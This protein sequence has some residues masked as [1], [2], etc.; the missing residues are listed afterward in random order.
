MNAAKNLFHNT[1]IIISKPFLFQ[2]CTS[3]SPQSSDLHMGMARHISSCPVGSLA[4]PGS[5]PHPPVPRLALWPLCA[6]TFHL[7][8]KGMARGD[9]PASTF[10]LVT[11]IP[12]FIANTILSLRG[13]DKPTLKKTQR[14]SHI[15]QPNWLLV[16]RN[17]LQ[18]LELQKKK[19]CNCKGLPS[20]LS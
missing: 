10:L 6:E 8:W 14:C 2:P 7:A 3:H 17:L 19:Y 18:T 4:D 12:A 5:S 1:K 11:Q 20:C 13:S 9:H 16:I 15:Q